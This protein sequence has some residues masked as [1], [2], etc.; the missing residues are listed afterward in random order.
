MI[1][2]AVVREDPAV[3][4]E[5][6][7]RACAT[8]VLLVAS[9]GCTALALRAQHPELQLVLVDPNP[10]QLRLVRAK[11]EALETLQGQELLRAFNVEATDPSGLCQRG[12]FEALFRALRDFLDA[13]VVRRDELEA[14]L[15]GAARGTDGPMRWFADPLW[16]VAFDLHFSDRLLH[17]LFTRAATQHTEPGSYP[18]YFRR[19]FEELL[20]APD[21]GRNRFLHHALLGTYL[22]LPGALP[23]YLGTRPR[24]SDI[25]LREGTVDAAPDLADFDLVGLSNV[26]DWMDQPACAALALRLARGL[27]SGAWVVFRQL[28]AGAQHWKHFAE[29]FEAPP[30]LGDEL[31]AMER[32]GFYTRVVAARRR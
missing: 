3:E 8:R 25:E 21:S 27:R 22:D 26:L 20:L 7:R 19:A 2:F 30:G 31:L 16:T 12:R 18:V 24:V 1:Q 28:G 15:R 14:F 4:L 6:V 32:S 11:F 5:L 13:F 10:H 23:P 17:A 9:G 29:H